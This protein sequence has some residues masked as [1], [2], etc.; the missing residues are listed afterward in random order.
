MAHDA[1]NLELSEYWVGIEWRKTVPLSEA[2]TF[3]GVFANQ[4]I[5][6]KLR[7][8]ATVEFLKREFP[9]EWDAR[10]EAHPQR[11][12]KVEDLLIL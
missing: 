3:P 9:I 12:H 10:P 5:V 6:C 7:D 2:K 1:D 8:T 4:N 11:P